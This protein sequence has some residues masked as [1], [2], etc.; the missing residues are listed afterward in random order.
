M[1]K[2]TEILKVNSPPLKTLFFNASW[3][4]MEKK[5]RENIVSTI[6]RETFARAKET[7]D[8]E[9][10]ERE[11]RF[12]KVSARVFPKVSAKTNES[13]E[14]WKRKEKEEKEM[15]EEEKILL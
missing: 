9:R 3:K 8:R 6:R 2:T 7:H 1:L 14:I 13:L 4:K 11:R 5:Q 10:E 12:A 15:K